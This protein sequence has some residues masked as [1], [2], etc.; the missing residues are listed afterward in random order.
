MK[1]ISL[2]AGA[3]GLDLGFE[4]AGFKIE[5]ANEY[6]KSIWDTYRYNHPNSYLNTQ[7]IRTID[8]NKLPDIDGIIGGPPCQSWSIAGARR[9][10]EDPRGQL[11]FNYIQIISA[12]NP[13]FFVAE[14][15]AG[16]LN[17]KYKS[18]I[19]EIIEQLSNAGEY[20]YNVQFKLLNTA[21]YGIPQERKRVFFIGYRKDLNK[22]FNF[23][24]LDQY[25]TKTNLKQ[26]IYDLKDALESKNILNHEYMKGGFS[27]IYLSRNRVRSWDEV[28]FTIQAGGRH[29][30]LHPDAPKMLKIEKDKM[31][32]V[33]GQEHL[34][35]RLTVRECARI[36]TFPDDFKFIY[37]NIADGYKMV[38]NAV[39]VKMANILATIIKSDLEYM[40]GLNNIL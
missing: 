25:K 40:S 31:I 3:G 21:E 28:S 20:G 1:L 15:V 38:G 34:Y 8:V 19:T 7:D 23:T 14:N 13:L 30:P 37:K 16:M 39:P 5:F 18:V 32:F 35:R 22:N 2:F 4:Q 33:P 24:Q 26:T 10:I 27:T 12:K 29:A 36:Q 9:G 11:F 6:D 17:I